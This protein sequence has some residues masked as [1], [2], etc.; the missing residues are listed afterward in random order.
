LPE[1]K[2]RRR[3]TDEEKKLEKAPKN[4]LNVQ[5]EEDFSKPSTS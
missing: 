1:G 5:R 2:G 3:G 4:I